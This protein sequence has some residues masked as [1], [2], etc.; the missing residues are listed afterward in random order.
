MVL[1]TQVFFILRSLCLPGISCV[2][3]APQ[4]I[5]WQEMG[6]SSFLGFYGFEYSL[7]FDSPLSQVKFYLPLGQR[8]VCDNG[9]SLLKLMS[10][11]WSSHFLSLV[12]RILLK[13]PSLGSKSTESLHCYLTWSQSNRK[14]GG[15]SSC[16]HIKIIFP[17]IFYHLSALDS[18]TLPLV[19][20]FSLWPRSWNIK[21]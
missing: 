6:F 14:Y 12:L 16:Q 1:R 13:H 21:T 7:L 10:K 11:V 18:L 3:T 20:P 5:W 9:Y 4:F 8:R 19:F 17:G 2:P 15:K